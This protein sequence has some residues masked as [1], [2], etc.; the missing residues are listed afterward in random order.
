D[1]I[2][3][4]RW[5]F[6][7][8]FASAPGYE[9]GVSISGRPGFNENRVGNAFVTWEKSEKANIGFEWSLFK[10]DLLQLT[11][12]VFREK[13]TD[14][15]T[16]PGT[17][18]DYVGINGLAPRNSGVVLNKGMDAELRLNKRW[19]DFRAF[20]NLQ[21]TYTKNKV[22]E[23]DQPAPAFFYQDLRGYEVG[24]QLGYKA[25]GFFRDVADIAESPV[26]NFRS[27]EH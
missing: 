26:Q 23:N 10:Q 27:E 8:D 13:R 21:F 12:D 17:V 6:I 1:K 11:F 4:A 15:L 7:S 19:N 16:A 22:L 20:A 9:F 18:P 3:D 14:I 2:G 24:Y 25:I 5:L